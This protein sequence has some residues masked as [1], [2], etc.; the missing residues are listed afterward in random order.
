MGLGVTGRALPT[1]QYQL[2]ILS[3]LLRNKKKKY[4]GETLS[5]FPW[6]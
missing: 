1:K 3:P 6:I 2:E 4:T 5:F